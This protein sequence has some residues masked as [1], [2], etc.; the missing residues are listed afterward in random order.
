VTTV[1]EP[2]RFMRCSGAQWDECKGGAEVMDEALP[3]VHLYPGD[4]PLAHPSNSRPV[5][6]KIMFA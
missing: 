3:A 1:K 2:L 5:Q 4:K 6:S